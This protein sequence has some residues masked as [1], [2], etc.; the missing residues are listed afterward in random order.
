MRFRYLGDHKAMIAFDYDF[1]DGATPDV[2]DEEA[3][4]KLQGNA[5]F[6]AVEESKTFGASFKEKKQ[7]AAYATLPP[8]DEKKEPADFVQD[9]LLD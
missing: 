1:A 8:E 7:K 9:T 5:E 2:T 3:I 4:A 6:E